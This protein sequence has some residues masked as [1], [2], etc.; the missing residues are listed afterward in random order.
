MNLIQAL[1]EHFLS[2]R[3]VPE[4]IRA[5][6]AGEMKPPHRTFI[7]VASFILSA[8]PHATAFSRKFYTTTEL[9]NDQLIR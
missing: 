6:W 3:M 1:H 7:T 4:Y 8:A 5:S 9:K 2:S